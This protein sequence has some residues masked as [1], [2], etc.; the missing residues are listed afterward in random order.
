MG[1]SGGGSQHIMAITLVLEV[2]PDWVL[3]AL[4]IS[5]TFNEIQ[6]YSSLEEL[7]M[8]F[9]RGR[10]FEHLAN[11]RAL[12][13]SSNTVDTKFASLYAPSWKALERSRRKYYSHRM[14]KCHVFGFSHGKSNE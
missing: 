4:D 10:I 11:S 1:T 9:V 2:N 12:L 5:N 3:I 13:L 7:A 14:R 6:R 8:Y